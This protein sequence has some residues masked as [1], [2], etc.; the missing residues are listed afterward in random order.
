IA[1]G[2]ET[3]L[4]AEDVEPVRRFLVEAL[5]EAGYRVLSAASGEDALELARGERIDLLLS[6]VV[7]PG[8]TGPELADALEAA[9]PGLPVLLMSGY[10][11]EGVGSRA[12]ILKPFDAYT[13]THRIR[14]LLDRA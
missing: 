5:E 7:M 3:I 2:V 11:E 10:A 4:L 12:F 1:A 13:L 14:G 6:D 9:I 8:I